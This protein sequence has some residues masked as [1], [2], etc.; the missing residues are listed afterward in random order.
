MLHYVIGQ[1]TELPFEIT[2][3]IKRYLEDIVY[4][5]D[6]WLQ[7]SIFYLIE[8]RS[9]SEVMTL[10]QR[11]NAISF[12]DYLEKNRVVNVLRKPTTDELKNIL[13]PTKKGHFAIARDHENEQKPVKFYSSI[14]QSIDDVLEQIVR[15][16]RAGYTSNIGKSYL[17][18]KLRDVRP[19]KKLLEYA[20][21]NG[22]A[23]KINV[24]LADL[25]K[26]G[27]VTEKSKQEQEKKRDIRSIELPDGTKWQDISI[28]FMDNGDHVEI[29]TKKITR[30]AT[31][32]EMGFEDARKKRPNA[33]WGF[34]RLLAMQRGELSWKNDLDMS[35]K[36]RNKIKKKVQVLSDTLKEYFPIREDPFYSY[37]KEKSYKI[38]INL[39][40][41][42]G[43]RE[44]QRYEDED[45]ISPEVKDIFEKDAPSVYEKEGNYN[46]DY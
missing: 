32:Q 36:E 23:E 6:E 22:E 16:T 33:Q 44:L 19:I 27:R 39:I 41:T 46:D 17:L 3:M 40:S 28:R 31:Y 21:E 14:H 20:K 30:N 37:R 13:G 4:L 42:S 35:V 7:G 26:A 24:D 10:K 12:W 45:D 29:T 18:L 43:R 2:P 9:G 15:A 1:K 38:K 25:I 34:L 5:H 8:P 11:K